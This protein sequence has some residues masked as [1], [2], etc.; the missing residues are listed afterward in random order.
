MRASHCPQAPALCSVP[1]CRGLTS[2]KLHSLIGLVVSC[3]ICSLYYT[4]SGSLFAPCILFFII[5]IISSTSCFDFRPCESYALHL[6]ELVFRL[7]IFQRVLRPVFLSPLVATSMSQ[8][9]N[10]LTVRFDFLG[11]AIC[12]VQCASL[13]LSLPAC[14]CKCILPCAF[15]L[16]ILHV[17]ALSLP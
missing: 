10:M 11:T 13:Y 8:F 17:T 5:R 16:G 6:V 15:R 14:A 7:P 1:C 4:F 2:N 9:G 3:V 12:S